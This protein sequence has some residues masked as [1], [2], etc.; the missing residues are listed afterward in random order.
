MQAYRFIVVRARSACNAFD[1]LWQVREVAAAGPEGEAAPP[2]AGYTFDPTSGLYADAASGMYYDGRSGGFYSSATG[3]WYSVD[4]GGQYVAWPVQAG[5][6]A[7][8]PQAG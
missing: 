7:A 5:G 6:G 8:A 3:L 2:P 4:A 1:V